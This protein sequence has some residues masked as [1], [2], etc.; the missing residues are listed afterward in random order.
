MKRDVTTL[1]LRDD[2]YGMIRWKQEEAGFE[3]W[4]LEFGNPDFVAYA[5]SYGARGFRVEKTGDLLEMLRSC[6]EA[7]G[8]NVIEVPID[9]AE[10]VNLTRR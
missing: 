2:S 6:L 3:D 8:V 10:N 5:E 4:G 9:Y 1:I 7:G